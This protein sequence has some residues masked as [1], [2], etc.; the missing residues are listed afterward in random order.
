MNLKNNKPIRFFSI[1]FM[2]SIFLLSFLNA[3]PV[4]RVLLE[5]HTGAWCGWCP[6]GSYIMDQILEKYPNQVIGVKIHNGDKMAI[7]EQQVLGQAMGLTGFPT[8]T[9]DRII[10]NVGGQGAIFLSRSAWKQACEISMQN[11]PK[12]DV[13]L[14]WSYNSGTGEINATLTTKILQT[15]SGDIRVNVYV[16]ENGVHGIGTGWDQHNYLSGRPGYEN[17]PYYNEPS[18]IVGYLHERVVRKM[19]GG[20]WGVQGVIPS[21]PGIG[22]SYTHDFSVQADGTWNMDSVFLVG[23]VQIYADNSREILNSVVGLNGVPSSE[24]TSSDAKIQLATSGQTTEKTFTLKN[25]SEDRTTFKINLETSD[26]TP[27]EWEYSVAVGGNI[28]KKKYDKPLAADVTLDAGASTTIKL[29]F[30]TGTKIGI[31]D[32][33]M[34]I[35]NQND[36][37]GQKSFGTMTVLSKDVQNIEVEAYADAKYSFKSQMASDG[38][39]DVVG[40]LGTEYSEIGTQLNKVSTLIWN[41]GEKGT[42]SAEDGSAISAAIS[43]GVNTMITGGIFV[44]TIKDNASSLLSYIGVQ[45][46]KPCFQGYSDGNINLMGYNG[47]PISNG[48]KQPGK[49]I[50]SL[51]PSLTPVGQNAHAFLKH[52]YADTIVAIRSTLGE[53]KVIFMGINPYIITSTSARDN[54][55]KKCLDWLG[56]VGPAIACESSLDFDDTE[57]GATSES[58]LT[59]EN[60]GKSDMIVNDIEVDYERQANF[61]IK[62]DKS[63]TVPAGSTY[64]LVVQFKPSYAIEYNSWLKIHSN[65]E[66]EPDKQITLTGKGIEA[67]AGPQIT[68]SSNELNFPDTDVN[69][70]SQMN[71][72]INNTGNETLNITNIA[73]PAA[74]ASAF[75]IEPTSANIEAGK[76]QTISITF[77]PT[78][79]KT[80]STKMT[81]TSNSKGGTVQVDLNAN[82]IVS[83]KDNYISQPEMSLSAVPNPIIDKAKIWL[84]LNTDIS[85]QI[86]IVL[87][88]VNGREIKQITNAN[89]GSGTYQFDFSSSNLSSGTYY[90]VAKNNNYSTQLPIVIVK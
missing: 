31:G 22:T 12:V 60:K 45:Y 9:V 30:N 79:A 84:N 51:T 8:G 16:V 4:K 46:N 63:F 43:D 24:L 81:I 72:D 64:D 88:D 23:L 17:N 49:L 6:D 39:N 82:G 52:Q 87:V 90:L 13:G 47:D 35:Y 34:T 61:I 21:N 67:S 75:T 19:L 14:I 53:T 80:Y 65:A 18:T 73:V 32:I 40:M 54:L 33:N 3:A 86:K 25:I 71:L 26:R 27:S 74:Y 11:A 78:E 83:V 55:I 10:W 28:I 15:V 29:Q 36:P 70:T 68:L 77:A 38:L 62:G 20:A 66:N 44:H 2:L 5:Q 50:Y 41:C 85:Q 56:G 57:T 76:K 42:V 1:A 37:S 89:Y 7:P 48:F 59:I 69:G 58:T